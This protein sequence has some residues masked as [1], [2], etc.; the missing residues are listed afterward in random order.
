MVDYSTHDPRGWCGDIRRGAALGRP[1]VRD[2]SRDYSGKV[3]LR[4]V[5]LDSGGYD[6]NGTYFGHGEPLYW[7]ANEDG[8]IDFMVR[9]VSRTRAKAIVHE[10]YPNARF[11]R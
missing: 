4:R 1:T 8:T 9:A 2:E 7:A 11:F 3:Y 5:S 6:P 10:S